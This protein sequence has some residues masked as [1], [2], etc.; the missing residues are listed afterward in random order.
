MC[1]LQGLE[2]RS[3][4]YGLWAPKINTLLKGI[5]GDPIAWLNGRVKEMRS[6][7]V[8]KWGLDMLTVDAEREAEE[9]DVK[10]HELMKKRE[11]AGAQRG[12]G[13]KTGAEILKEMRRGRGN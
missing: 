11:N 10:R 13:F 6:R 2:P 4:Q 3:N 7:G 5:H 8:V 9:R 1:R 12:G